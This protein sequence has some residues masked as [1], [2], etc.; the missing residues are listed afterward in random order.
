[1]NNITESGSIEHPPDGSLENA[2]L[3]GHDL[4]ES[5]HSRPAPSTSDRPTITPSPPIDNALPNGFEAEDC[6]TAQD[7]S[8]GES[9]PAEWIIGWRYPASMAAL[10]LIGTLVAIAHHIYY[11]SL[12]N[13]PVRSPSQQTWAI[14]IGT[15]LAFLNKTCLT[16]VMGMI[17]TQQIWLTVRRKF[18]TLQGIDS[19]FKL[20]NDPTAIFNR[21]LITRAK[22]LVL[23][24]SLAW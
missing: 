4:P 21:D 22:A 24:A 9:P 23:M 12:E 18:I 7:T 8:S 10:Y 17:T 15:G 2:Q 1:M 20:M 6:E 14:R 3:L 5:P 13:T 11:Q 16:A 19:M